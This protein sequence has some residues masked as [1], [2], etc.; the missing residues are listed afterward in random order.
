MSRLKVKLRGA[1]VTDIV[2]NPE[3]EY[4]AGRKEDC[5][6]RLQPEKGISR[7]HF[8]LYY[9]D[10]QWRL[11]LIARFGEILF[12]GTRIES[13]GLQHGSRFTVPP[14]EFEFLE[15]AIDVG[16]PEAQNNEPLAPPPIPGVETSPEQDKTI[17]GV[18][19]S[20]PYLKVMGPDGQAK[21]MLKLESGNSWVA[22]RDSTCN[23]RIKD[24]RVSRR[25]FEIQKQGLI[26][27]II[28]LASVNGTLVNG[29]PISATDPTTLKSGD[30]ISVLDNHFYFELHD[31]DFKHRLNSLQD[32][33]SVQENYQPYIDQ[34]FL[35][36][37]DPVI[38]SQQVPPPPAYDDELIPNVPNPNFRQ[39]DL[40]V[41]EP[42]SQR[43]TQYSTPSP[44]YGT[45]G[46]GGG[47][48]QTPGGEEQFD[49]EGPKKFKI[50]FKNK[51]HVAV[52]LT[53]VLVLSYFIYE[54]NFTSTST[55]GT[56]VTQAPD[57]RLP[58]DRLTDQQKTQVEHLY[59]IAD[60]NCSQA[61][62]FECKT[63]LEELHVILPEGY[64]DSLDKL[65]L[66][67]S[68]IEAQ[69]EL[70][71]EEERQRAANEEREFI[72]GVIAECRQKLHA[73]IELSEVE[74]CLSEAERRNATFPAL[75]E[76]KIEVDRIIS[77]RKLREEEEERQRAMV[78]VLEG[79]YKTAEDFQR[80]GYALRAIASYEKV[81]NSDLP[82]PRR[83]KITSQKRIEEIRDKVNERVS[84]KISEA[85]DLYAQGNFKQSILALREALV[86]DP[87]NKQVPDLIEQYTESLNE[88]LKVIYT[89]SQLEEH[90]GN[91]DGQEGRPGAIDKLKRILELDLPEGKYYRKASGRLSTLR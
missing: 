85:R 40:E 63:K 6:I 35:A 41:A 73:K 24:S 84:K 59:R 55:G 32:M 34:R 71:R 16:A 57:T 31:P 30:A 47:A 18:A 27:T 44:Y 54:Q 11:E 33:E 23:I 25:Q 62:Y 46:G 82:D 4:I 26:F 89:E 70:R 91:I 15:T 9:S 66:A 20:M 5:N 37:P 39:E 52:L 19:P 74:N 60:T 81:V 13:I 56:G 88:K 76:F 61:K 51:K 83:R 86:Y 7:E 50:D 69:E 17:I 64:Q 67:D 49:D 79:M 38:P 58:F 10:N 3:Q 29:A 87:K 90:F 22:G 12:E 65:K 48:Y 21:E 28:D 2:L 1:H 78:K 68:Y 53:V 36:P 72:E 75:V 8:K 45:T 43:Q 80:Q 14:Y 77:E 42:R